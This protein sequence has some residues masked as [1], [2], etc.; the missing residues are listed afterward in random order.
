KKGDVVFIVDK[1]EKNI[2]SLST[3]FGVYSYYHC[4]LYIG[5]GSIIEAIPVEGVIQV[6]LYKYSDKKTL[7][8]LI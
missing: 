2:S 6:K 7:V 8:Y 4:A 5:Y 1:A 3:G